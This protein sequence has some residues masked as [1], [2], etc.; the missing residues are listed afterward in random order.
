MLFVTER[1][2]A[3]KPLD[4]RGDDPSSLE[5]LARLEWPRPRCGVQ[6]VDAVDECGVSVRVGLYELAAHM[7]RDARR[8]S[9]HRGRFCAAFYRLLHA[10]VAVDL[11]QQIARRERLSEHDHD[12]RPEHRSCDRS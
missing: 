12:P 3:T 2:G 6:A 10:R 8:Q 9:R 1:I 4:A 7:F 11:T 5:A